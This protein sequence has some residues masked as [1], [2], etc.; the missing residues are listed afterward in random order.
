[1]YRIELFTD[2][3]R[4]S[5]IWRETCRRDGIGELHLVRVD[6]FEHAIGTVP[7]AA[8]GFDAAVEFPPHHRTAPIRRVKLLN[9]EFTGVVHD[10]EAVALGSV[11][12][13]EARY[14]HYRGIMPR[15]DNTPRRQ[16]DATIFARST[17]GAYQAWLEEVLRYTR[18][19]NVGDERLV[20]VNA[21]NEWAEGAHLEPDRKYGRAYLEATRN[22]VRAHLVRQEN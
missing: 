2:T 22:A 6:S 19:Q 8:Q 1:V 14:P 15:W 10:Y 18:E 4:T 12:Y 7:P 20:F 17:P 9:D 11:R 5:E 16:D 13:K 21:W 3:R